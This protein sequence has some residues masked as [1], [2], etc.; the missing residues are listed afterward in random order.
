MILRI[1]AEIADRVIVLQ[2]GRI[3]EEGA[4]A[5]VFTAPRQAYT[6]DLLEAIPGRDF[7]DQPGFAAD[8][9]RA[10]RIASGADAV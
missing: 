3:V 10:S 4:T 8:A 2:K 1:A 6:R 5:E 7:F 9:R